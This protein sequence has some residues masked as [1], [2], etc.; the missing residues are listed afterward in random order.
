VPSPTGELAPSL[1]LYGAQLV[2]VSASDRRVR[3]IVFS[4]GGGKLQAALGG[5][6]IGT[7]A[8]RA[9][10]NDVRFRLPVASVKA[11][12]SASSA[13]ASASVLSLTSLSL[14]GA[15][16]ATVKRTVSIRPTAKKAAAKK[17]AAKKVVRKQPTK[18]ARR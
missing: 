9:G 4:S 13:R 8:L 15:A 14:D 18:K 10:N 11:L 1:H 17:P 5:R 7:F 16:G 6:A 3:L 12:R 2:R